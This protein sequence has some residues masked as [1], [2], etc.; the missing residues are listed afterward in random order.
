VISSGCRTWSTRNWNEHCVVHTRVCSIGVYYASDLRHRLVVETF[1]A[2]HV[3]PVARLHCPLCSTVSYRSWLTQTLTQF[4]LC[5][6]WNIER[7]ESSTWYDFRKRTFRLST[8]V[9][10]LSD[11]HSLFS[12]PCLLR[13]TASFLFK[14]NQIKSNMTLITI[15]RPQPSFNYRDLEVELIVLIQISSK[16]PKSYLLLTFRPLSEAFIRRSWY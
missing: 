4:L 15:D 8:A 3:G 13:S 14:P 9:L 16:Q 11:L 6:R 7:R 10:S 1:V 2:A 5:T 12:M